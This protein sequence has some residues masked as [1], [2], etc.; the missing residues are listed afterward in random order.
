[1]I[2]GTAPIVYGYTP[3]KLIAGT[4]RSKPP[5]KLIDEFDPMYSVISS[6]SINFGKF[7]CNADFF[8]DL[9]YNNAFRKSFCES[10]VIYYIKNHSVIA[11]GIEIWASSEMFEK[12]TEEEI[13][14]CVIPKYQITIDT[15][16]AHEKYSFKAERIKNV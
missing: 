5:P 9:E 14:N 7:N 16:V 3:K 1:M 6:T 11:N 4:G 15:I 10:F 13:K 2:I 12:V 8:Q